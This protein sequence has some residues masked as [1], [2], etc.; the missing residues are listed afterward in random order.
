MPI[1]AVLFDVGG[2]ILRTEDPDPRMRWEN[3][4]GL[5]PGRLVKVVFDNP[6]ALSSTRG[7]ALEE[8]VWREVGRSLNL[9]AEQLA[10]LRVDFFAGDRWDENLLA[11]IRSLRPG[12]RTGVISN[13]WLGAQAAMEKWINAETFDVIVFSGVE[14]CAKPEERI[15][16]LALDRLGLAPQE[17]IFFDDSRTNVEGAARIGMQAVLFEG[18]LQAMERVRNTV[19]PP[20]LS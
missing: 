13:G 3:R 19:N 10:Q 11:F 6:V 2:V 5:A 15:Y 8:D 20:A 4:L 18:P 9:P 16:R 17:A 12:V 1:R 7:E 14:K